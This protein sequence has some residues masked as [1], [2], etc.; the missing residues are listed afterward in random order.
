VL[1]GARA[2][3]AARHPR[4]FIEMHGDTMAAKRQNAQAVV[5][6]LVGLGYDEILH[7]ESG[8]MST[9]TNATIAAEGHLYC[10]RRAAHSAGR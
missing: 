10:Q 4:L 8:T 9:V 7:V 6:L 1:E 3:L 5:E 2:T